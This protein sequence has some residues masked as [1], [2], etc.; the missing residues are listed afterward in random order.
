MEANLRLSDI[1]FLINAHK[2]VL[3]SSVNSYLNSFLCDVLVSGGFSFSLF[4]FLGGLGK[5]RPF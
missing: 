4:P 2:Q 3:A 1:L 5:I